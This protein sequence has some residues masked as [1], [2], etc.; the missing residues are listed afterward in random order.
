[1]YT[2]YVQFVIWVIKTTEVTKY[3]LIVNVRPVKGLT[4]TQLS[5]ENRHYTGAVG[6]VFDLNQ[7]N[8]E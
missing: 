5:S 7:G 4:T 6:I 8:L 3:V 2:L 1:M